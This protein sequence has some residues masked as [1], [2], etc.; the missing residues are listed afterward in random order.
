MVDFKFKND[1]LML[2]DLQLSI[3]KDD[4]AQLILSVPSDNIVLSNNL[5][6]LVKDDRFVKDTR[7]EQIGANVSYFL[8]KIGVYS[9][10]TDQRKD[11]SGYYPIYYKIMADQLQLLGI[12]LS[13][14]PETS[15]TVLEDLNQEMGKDGKRR[16]FN[17]YDSRAVK[18]LKPFLMIK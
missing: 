9:G 5:K 12:Q 6:D 14:D 11:K 13:E 16:K 1:R 7:I 4:V 3:S 17:M 15:W 18:A 10:N 8:R 2:N